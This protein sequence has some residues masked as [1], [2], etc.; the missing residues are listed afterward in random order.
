MC[1]K[2]FDYFCDVSTPPL[3]SKPAPQ[4]KKNNPNLP[5]PLHVIR[6]E[7]VL[8]KLPMH[9]LAK[10]GNFRIH[11]MKTDE[12]GKVD[13]HWEVSPNPQHGDPRQLSYKLDTIIINQRID[14]LDRPLPK[15]IKLGSLR[16]IAKE[17]GLPPSDTNSIREAALKNAATFITAKITY[18]GKDRLEWRLEAGF[19]RYSVIFTGDKLPDGSRADAVYV[20]LNDPYWEVLNNAP[21][22]P[23]NYGYLKELPPT[24][25]RFYEIISYRI[26]STIKYG[27]SHAKLRYSEYCT[28][29]AQHRNY[30]YDHVKKQMY[31]VH[32]PHL[33]SGYIQKVTIETTTD[34]EGQLDWM[35]CYVPGPKAKAEYQAFNRKQLIEDEVLQENDQEVTEQDLILPQPPVSASG[36]RTRQVLPSAI[37]SHRA[38]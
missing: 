29:S 4:G 28:F 18:K 36:R 27:R 26:F 37:S 17:L 21:I 32:R 11:I 38:R 12:H 15:L 6:T 20:N 9:N 23:L 1:E 5:V 25:Q 13:L 10:R 30:D 22:R 31:K 3:V 16:E 33:Q 19:T 7:T 35:M 34:A 24:P 8:S 14:Q 2:I